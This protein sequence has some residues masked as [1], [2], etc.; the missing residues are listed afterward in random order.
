MPG[1]RGGPSSYLKQFRA[2]CRPAT[3]QTLRAG[4]PS[5]ESLR[6][7]ATGRGRRLASPAGRTHGSIL[8]SGRTRIPW[9][10]TRAPRDSDGRARLEA[11]TSPAEAS[12]DQARVV[13]LGRLRPAGPE[14][15]TSPAEAGTSPAEA[16]TSPASRKPRPLARASQGLLQLGATAPSLDPPLHSLGSWA[17][18]LEC[19]SNP[20]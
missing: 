11:G 1:S 9:P 17:T 4:P 12:L 15:G 3:P 19:R 18:G 16:G 6:G 7:C 14:A 2:P 8:P 13:R 10:G 5:S 20:G